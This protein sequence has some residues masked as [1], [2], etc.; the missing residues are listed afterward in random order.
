MRRLVRAQTA[1]RLKKLDREVR[2]VSRKPEDADA[3]HDLRVAI[4]RLK[5]ALGVFEAW[6]HPR[7]V[8]RILDSV[9]KLMDR[10][11]AVRNCDIAVEVLRAARWR[12]PELLAGLE[13]ERRHTR[14]ELA[15]KLEDWR[16]EDRV[17][18]WR[19]HLRVGHSE[20]K[21]SPGEYAARLLPGMM[22]D[23]FRAG[24][25]A[26]RLDSTRRRMHRFRLKTKRMRYT[27]EIF[28]PVYG[29][30]TKGI[31]E[32][33]KGLQETLGAINDCATTIEMIRRDR[34][35]ADAVRLLATKRE[36][37]F[38]AYW[39]THFRPNNRVQWKAVLSAADW[40][41]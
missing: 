37:E 39:K 7:P 40:K 9:S 20:S 6:F 25:W 1:A 27:L 15:R 36:A 32:S 21:G 26:A 14:E 19:G 24:R 3:I 2:R 5:E 38:R 10:C 18:E 41:K 31:M 8:K 16:K 17:R 23:L 4:R 34:G 22:E 30:K 13:A 35:A 12:D 29:A 11:A 28:E 33:L